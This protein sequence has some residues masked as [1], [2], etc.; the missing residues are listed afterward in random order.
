ME[1]SSSERLLENTSQAD[2]ILE[3]HFILEEH[4]HVHQQ[5]KQPTRRLRHCVQC[6]TRTTFG[7]V[8][9]PYRNLLPHIYSTILPFKTCQAELRFILDTQ[10]NPRGNSV[11]LEVRGTLLKNSAYIRLIGAV[12]C[13][14][15]TSTYSHI[16]TSGG[17]ISILNIDI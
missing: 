16:Q 12:A 15:T 8:M 13:M 6:D 3:E 4:V 7:N 9:T 5:N 10:L 2:C 14:K 11:C 1:K 17:N